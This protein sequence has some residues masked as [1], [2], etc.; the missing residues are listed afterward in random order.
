MRYTTIRCPNCK[1]FIQIMKPENWSYA[2]Y[3]GEPI[4]YCSYCLKPY[5][6]GKK[7]W[8]SM[9]KAQQ[10]NVRNNKYWHALV[11]VMIY[12]VI[13]ALIFSYLIVPYFPIVKDYNGEIFGCAFIVF[14]FLSLRIEKSD[15]ADEISK[16]LD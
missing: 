3:L 16:N 9:T 8:N 11:Y 10:Q 14:Y 12:T 5:K 7:K 6:T 15:L 1:A 13:F 4:A 2:D